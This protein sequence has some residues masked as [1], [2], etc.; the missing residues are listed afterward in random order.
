MTRITYIEPT[1]EL[2]MQE[3]VACECR[4]NSRLACQIKAAPAL[5]GL[6]LRMPATQE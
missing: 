6:V 4:P 3:N 2:D 1:G 5:G